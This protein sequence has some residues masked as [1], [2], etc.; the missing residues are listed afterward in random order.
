MIRSCMSIFSNA[1]SVVAYVSV[2]KMIAFLTIAM[3]P[4]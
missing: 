1:P 4:V 3:T 2:R